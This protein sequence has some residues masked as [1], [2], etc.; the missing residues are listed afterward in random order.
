MTGTLFDVQRFSVHDGPG[1]RTTVFLKGCPLRCAWCQNPEG[2][3]RTIR[4]WN[5][6]NLCVGCGV[7]VGVCPNAALSMGED[8]IPAIDHDK[9][10]RCGK[11]VD[12]CLYNAM[13]LDGF[14]I[15]SA[16][17][18]ERLLADAVFFAASG[19][20]VTFSGGEPLAQAAFVKDTASRLHEKGVRTAIETSLEGSWDDLKGLID[21]IDFFQVDLKLADSAL[22]HAATGVGN[23]RIADNFRRLASALRGSG[24]LLL[25]IPAIP[26]Y[27]D[28]EANLA[29]LARMAADVDPELDVELMNFNPLAAA[30]YRRM[31]RRYAL[32]EVAA[33]YSSDDMDALR[34]V[35]ERY[36]P[37][38]RAGAREQ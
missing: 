7:C 30:K 36:L 37:R 3:E 18:A 11:C 23:E 21:C 10:A 29:A 5:F 26:G 20:G 27:T 16:E 38:R 12:E 34:R 19:G 15:D 6:D 22:H 14:E 33:G 32:A 1:I 25:R 17:L 2:L 13:A 24:R 31:R 4:L 28:D 8:G 9:C 35:L